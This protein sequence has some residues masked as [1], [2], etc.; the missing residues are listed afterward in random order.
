[1]RS[2]YR[3]FHS[4]PITLFIRQI[5]SSTYGMQLSLPKQR[6]NNFFHEGS[7]LSA[8]SFCIQFE[9]KRYK[10]FITFLN[11]QKNCNS[12]T[13]SVQWYV[14]AQVILRQ[15]CNIWEILVIERDEGF[16]QHQSFICPCFFDTL[17]LAKWSGIKCDVG[18][19]S[20]IE[21]KIVETFSFFRQ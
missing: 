12:I 16:H 4:D 18:I 9:C 21:K 5:Y 13:D 20:L 15:N 7:F 8:T 6:Q 17:L 2:V 11:K 10:Y 19:V 14:F 3:N 1:M